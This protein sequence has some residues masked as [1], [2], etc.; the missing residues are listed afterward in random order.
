MEAVSAPAQ[1]RLNAGLIGVRQRADALPD[2]SDEYT[3]A[4][5]PRLEGVALFDAAPEAML[6]VQGGVVVQANGRARELFGPDAVGQRADVLIIGWRRD[7][8]GPFEAEARRADGELLP[9]EVLVRDA[10]SA[11]IVS[12]RDARE[13][14]AGREALR[15]LFEVEAR[16]RGLVEQVPAVVYEDRGD[17]TIYV[18]PQIEQILGVTPEAYI[19]DNRMWIRMVH[20]DDRTW[21]QEQSDAFIEGSGGD[22]DD[23]RM[24]R[25]DGRIVWI[26]DRAYAYRDEHGHVILEQGLLFDVTE[27]KEAEA[28]VKHMAYHD[29]LTGLA[30]RELFRES[31]HL[32]VE[33]A[34]R[35]GTAIAVIFL[36]LDNFKQLN[37]TKGHHVG[38]QLLAALADRLTSATRDVDLVARQG[39]DEFLL[40]LADLQPA[41]A[42][43]VEHKVLER[44]HTVLEQPIAVANGSFRVQASIG[45]SRFP[46]DAEDEATLL[47][48]ADAAMYEAKRTSRGGYRIFRS[49]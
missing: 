43:Q 36:D 4:I 30:N 3:P 7:G 33:R 31:L 42:D 32:A 48:H 14:L 24:V 16:Y 2:M 18:S 19:A 10:G 27:L 21:V 34:R 12:I 38:D 15:Q 5:D 49:E 6:A 39:G 29:A 11:A 17:E 37:D 26:R 47:Q 1:Q 40:M 8:V 25:P 41:E 20:P 44:L 22:L 13:L 45:V 46:D 9:V 35:D 23:Y 28:R